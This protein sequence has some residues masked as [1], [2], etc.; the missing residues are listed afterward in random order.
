MIDQSKWLSQRL[1]SS[2][3]SSPVWVGLYESIEEWH[4]CYVFPAIDRLRDS[5]KTFTK[6]DEALTRLI[7]DM[8]DFFEVPEIDSETRGIQR[9]LDL[10]WRKHELHK[11]RTTVAFDSYVNRVMKLHG[12]S[13]SWMPLYW[14]KDEDYSTAKFYPKLKEFQEFQGNLS[15]RG[16]VYLDLDSMPHKRAA[17]IDEKITLGSER[18]RE[19]IPEHLVING[20]VLHRRVIASKVNY[21][22]IVNKPLVLAFGGNK[23]DHHEAHVNS[24]NKTTYLAT[25]NSSAVIN[26]GSNKG[27]HHEAHVNSTNKMPAVSV[28]T[29]FIA[30]GKGGTTR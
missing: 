30:R 13:L 7:G 28:K 4:A 17:W 18:A 21:Y 14:R 23:G 29:I 5:R 6:D 26:S 12:I 16:Y 19:I 25:M 24:T 15:S 27:D 8:G 2:R 10:L 22:A 9:H 3:R 20:S 11:K 1:T